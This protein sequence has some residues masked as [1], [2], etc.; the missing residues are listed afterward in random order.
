MKVIHCSDLHLDSKMETNLTAEQA[1]QRNNEICQTFSRMVI[2]AKENRVEVILIAGDLFDTQRIR[3]KTADYILDTIISSPSIDFLYLR[4]NHDESE[5]AFAG[6]N[7]PENLKFF[8]EIWTYFSYGSVVIAGI[9]IGQENHENLYQSLVLQKDNVNLVV[10]HGQESTKPGRGLV[11]T[12]LLKGKSI[13]YL[14]LGHFHSYKKNQLG[15]RGFY[16]YSGC[17][18][19]RGFDECGEKGFVLVEIGGNKVSSEFVPFSSRNLVDVPVDITGLITILEIQTEMEK[20]SKGI[21]SD[22]LVKFIL[23][24]SFSLETQ[25]DFRF[26]LPVFQSKFFFVKIVDESKLAMTPEE[27][28]YDISLKGEFIRMVLSSKKSDK[29]KELIIRYGIQALTGEEI[30]LWS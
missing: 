5:Q 3:R 22:S 9:E 25:K 1:S 2:Y 30:L 28:K 16:C 24:G 4:G 21:S 23:Q 7:I 19:G 13:D 11:C 18:D 8:S 14:A 17:L 29:E 15:R 27:Y 6:R 12:S 10:M 20:A 26:L